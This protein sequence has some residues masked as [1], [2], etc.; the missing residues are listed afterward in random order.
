MPTA[1]IIDERLGRLE[2]GQM[3]INEKIDALDRNLCQRFDD[4]N[5]RLKGID[6]RLNSID[7]RIHSVTITTFSTGACA[8]AVIVGAIIANRLI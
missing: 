8:T 3:S 2:E 6:C 4:T 7:T 5:K 1:M